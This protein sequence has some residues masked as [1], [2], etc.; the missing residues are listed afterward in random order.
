[1]ATCF[2]GVYPQGRTL[3]RME[4]HHVSPELAKD[5]FNCPHCQAYAHQTWYQTEAFQLRDTDGV[6]D[7]Y[8]ALK[9]SQ[10]LPP[11]S[12]SLH[13]ATSTGNPTLD[14]LTNLALAIAPKT[15][16]ST[17]LLISK[18]E[19]CEEIAVWIHGCLLWPGSGIAP[20]PNPDLPPDVA[21]DYWEAS[22]IVHESPR[23]AAAL[24]RLAIEKLC[25]RLVSPDEKLN[26][27][28]G[29]L[30]AR[31][32][33]PQIQQALDYVRVI[34]NNAVH[35]GKIDLKD[36]ADTAAT[37]FSVVNLVADQMITKPKN[38]KEM[39]DALPV[40][41]RRKIEKRDRKNPLAEYSPHDTS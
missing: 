31:G 32:L 30:V 29:A 7:A 6:P 15:V 8:G 2:D 19:K 17:H 23:G 41:E 26:E 36:D 40:E 33:D 27:C 28:I 3:V 20:P 34:G 11:S 5:G 21:D 24:L 14:S 16:V 1:M 9:R 4:S 18:C 13:S 25:R 38:M 39:F 10:H 22:A 37:L 35:P 12:K